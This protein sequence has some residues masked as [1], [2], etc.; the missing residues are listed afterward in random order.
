MEITVKHLIERLKIENPEAVIDFS[1]LDF[2]RV[3]SRGPLTVQV[4][5]SQSVYKNEDGNVVVQNHQ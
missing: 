4:E 1:G 3:K 2:L 5:F